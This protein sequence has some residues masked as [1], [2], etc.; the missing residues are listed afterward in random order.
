M[1]KL[2]VNDLYKK[3]YDILIP[4]IGIHEPD[5]Y[6][7][8]NGRYNKWFEIGKNYLEIVSNIDDAHLVLYNADVHHL[9]VELI[10]EAKKHNKKLL[11]I[12]NSDFDNYLCVENS[13]ILRTSFY[14]DSRKPNEFAIPAFIDDIVEKYFDGVL[15]YKNKNDVPIISF[16]GYDNSPVRK[17][18]VDALLQS[19]IVKPNFIIRSSFWGGTTN[20]P[21][22]KPEAI[23]VRQEFV[24][25]LNQGD[26]ALCARGGGN[27]S[28]RLYEAMAMGK[29]PLF[30]N[31]RCVLPFE[32]QIN[33]KDLCVWVEE[34]EISHIDQIVLRHHNQISNEEFINKQKKCRQIWEDYLSPHGF[35]S[36]I[37]TSLGIATP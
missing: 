16:C 18:A 27:F 28:Y 36:K 19:R 11:V 29:I 26:Y 7:P 20:G 14:S 34:K 30:V 2:Y 13:I 17:Q 9:D 8:I 1:F 24:E 33:W 15:P 10:A 12:F 3:R 35:Y 6:D 22:M 31:S 32:N 5:P 25:N 4:Y 23:Q 21:L 37:F